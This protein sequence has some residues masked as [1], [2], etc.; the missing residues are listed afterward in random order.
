MGTMVGKVE[1]ISNGTSLMCESEEL[2]CE[3]GIQQVQ[4][5]MMMD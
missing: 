1:S 4:T 3:N 5:Q 2:E